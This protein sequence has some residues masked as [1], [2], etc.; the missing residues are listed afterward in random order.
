MATT[1]RFLGTKNT[2]NTGR[3]ILVDTQTLTTGATIACTTT[4]IIIFIKL[5]RFSLFNNY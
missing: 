3:K 2:D 4:N 5:S 1:N